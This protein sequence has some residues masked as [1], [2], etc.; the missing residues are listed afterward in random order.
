MILSN[1]AL[2][3]TVSDKIGIF[4]ITV[5]A[6]GDK[7]DERYLGTLLRGSQVIGAGLVFENIY[8]INYSHMNCD[9]KLKGFLVLYDSMIPSSFLFFYF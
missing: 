8:D 5:P 9:V 7:E 2:L 1:F 3:G 6:F 4:S